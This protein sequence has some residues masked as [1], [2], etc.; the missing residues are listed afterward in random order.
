M[1]IGLEDGEDPESRTFNQTPQDMLRIIPG[2]TS[3]GLGRLVLE[4]QNVVEVAN[5]EESVLA[6]MIG[7]EAARQ[8]RWFF[9]RSV[10]DEG[11][12]E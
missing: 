6:Q 1:Q 10:W 3:K 5:A 9:D 4:M 8:I 2:V 7:K 11:E 12:P